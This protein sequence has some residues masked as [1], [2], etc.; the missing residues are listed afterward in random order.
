METSRALHE[1]LG[2]SQRLGL[3]GAKPIPEVIEHARRFVTALDGVAGEVVDIGAGGGVPGLVI[4]HDRPDLRLTLIDR[5]SKRTDFLERVVRRLGW[6]DRITVIAGDVEELVVSAPRGFDAVVA[7][8]FGP[9]DVTLE[10]GVA[11]ARRGGRV[12]I[13]EPPGGDRWHSI[14]LASSGVVERGNQV[15][16][17]VVFT[18]LS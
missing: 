4:A 2:S 6:G 15:A 3:L 12:V 8:G 9:P 18:V 17:V 7:R 13:S 1:A 5:R 11:L 16:G 10:I 14:P